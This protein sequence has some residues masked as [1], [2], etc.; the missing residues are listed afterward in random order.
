[1]VKAEELKTNVDGVIIC[2]LCIG[3][4]SVVDTYSED[5]DE[6]DCPNCNS[7]GEMEIGNKILPMDYVVALVLSKYSQYTAI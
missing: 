5:L 6:V 7:T 2:P 4:G 1:M 3:K